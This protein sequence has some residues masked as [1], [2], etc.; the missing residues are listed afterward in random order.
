MGRSRRRRERRGES[1]DY[2]GAHVSVCLQTPINRRNFV[3]RSPQLCYGC[4]SPSYMFLRGQAPSLP[5]LRPTV[6]FACPADKRNAPAIGLVVFGITMKRLS[7]IC[8]APLLFAL[9]GCEASKSSTPLSPSV[10]GPI[11]GVD[12]SAP[13]PLEPLVG[14][15]VAVDRQPVTLLI[16]NASS[17]GPRPLTLSVEMA[18]DVNFAGKV[19]AA[20]QYSAWRKRPHR[21]SPS[22]SAGA[23]DTTTTGV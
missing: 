17:S 3:D 7:L 6:A 21:A 11:P 13:K 12:I 18:T 23:R 10:A 4:D 14:S 1:R 20:D 19:F 9:V 5:L 22:R 15:K 16:E 2:N 8:F